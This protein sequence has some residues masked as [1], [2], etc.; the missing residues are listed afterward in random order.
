LGDLD[1]KYIAPDDYVEYSSTDGLTIGAILY[2]PKDTEPGVKLPALVEVHGGP[3]GQYFRTF[4]MFDQILLN[5]G[6]VILKPNFRGST[7]YGR[8]FQDMNIQ[9]I[10]GGDLEDVVAGVDFL[11]TLDYI[12][13]ERIGIFGGSY[14]GYMTFWATVK[15]PELWK[16]GAASIGITDWKLLYEESMPHFKH[17]LHMMFGLIEENEE[18]YKERSPV[19][20]VENLKAPLLIVHGAN[21]PRCPLSQASVYRDKL[22]N[23][24]W[25]EGKEGEKTFEYLVFGDIGHG[26]YTDQEF[27]IRSFKVVLDFFKRRL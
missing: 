11:K 4:S 21:D 2:K 22:L 9:D 14:G 8:E 5:N 6:F 23:L 25:K 10:G 24:G 12:D 27:R 15:R 18:L 1:A 13:P 17:Y 19:N 26:G 20:F 16:A 7:G 3:T